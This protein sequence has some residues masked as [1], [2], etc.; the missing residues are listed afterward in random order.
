M[1]VRTILKS[2][3]VVA[4]LNS[5]AAMGVSTVY[6]DFGPSGDTYSDVS[7][8]YNNFS[9]AGTKSLVDTNNASSAISLQYAL[10]GGTYNYASGT[11]RDP[12]PGISSDLT[13]DRIYAGTGGAADVGEFG[14]TLTFSG[15]DPAGTCNITAWPSQTG[16]S[17][18]WKVAAGSGDAAEYIQD[19][20]TRNNAFEWNNITP[21]ASG[22]VVITGRATSN[23]K[24]KSVGLSGVAITAI[25][26][27]V[28]VDLSFENGTN[29]MVNAKSLNQS[30]QYSLQCCTNL[31][32][33]SWESFGQPVV[34]V[35]SNSWSD[36][37]NVPFSFY[38]LNG[39]DQKI[40][41]ALIRSQF[42]EFYSALA[43]ADSVTQANLDSM[44]AGG[45]W[46]DV[47]YESEATASWP[48]TLHLSRLLSMAESYANHDSSFYEDP[49]LLGA[50][51][52]GLQHWL[53]EDYYNS[54]WFN[55]KI[56][57]P[58][59]FE[60]TF[61]LL[62]DDLPSAMY[63]EAR[64]KIFNSTAMDMTGANQVSLATKV[65]MRGLL[66]E[67]ASLMIRASE[68][69]W[70]ELYVTTDEGIQPDWSFH[71]HGPQQQF[72]N[73]GLGMTAMMIE[74][75]LTMRDTLYAPAADRLAILRN[76]M[77]EG[78]SWV[79]WN[80][81]MDISAVGRMIYPG[82]QLGKGSKLKS[83]L[84]DMIKIDSAATALYEQ[85]LAPTN[86][87]VGHKSF[88]R[89]DMAVHRRP[90]WYSSV[91][92]C[93]TRVVGTETANEQ[94][95]L[96]IH[97][98]DGVHYVYQ[99][100]AEYEDAMGLWDWHRLSG[101]TCDQGNHSLKPTG[102]DKDYGES[103]FVGVLNDGTNGMATM[104]YKRNSL[105]A[106]KSWF[107]GEDSVVCLGAGIGGTTLGSVY[108]SVQQSWLNGPVVTASGIL[109]NGTYVLAA[110]SWVQHNGIGYHMLQPS[111]LH[112]DTVTGNWLDI[113]STFD[114]GPVTGSVFSIWI[115][116]GT[117]PVDGTYAYTLYP[118]TDAADMESKI[119]ADN[120]TVLT[121]S[122]SL[123]AI[124]S[125]AGVQ[126][127]FYSAGILTTPDGMLVEV[128]QPCLL[129]LKEDRFIACEP[130]QQLASLTVTVDGISYPV[131]LS[132]GGF[133]GRQVE[134]EF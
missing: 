39:Q 78:E 81:R 32:L 131:S 104:I 55:W 31:V 92:M 103:A 73:Y 20:T 58:L 114:D 42:I 43:P 46:A 99:D 106:R 115:D 133:A 111:T 67:D 57:V 45:T 100:G 76:F 107:F 38:R 80:G 87:I 64:W 17:S 84:L 37:R 22:N 4:A 82:S 60:R 96:G 88:W 9:G 41:M 3:A 130:T 124:E 59:L 34:G 24:W 35:R 6:I 108:T 118:R 65:F 98:A 120:T 23:S 62:D 44:L 134:V 36:L 95:L 63:T 71:Q 5:A 69:L 66:D 10:Y 74:Q 51:L 90:D 109:T 132:A 54:N 110:D 15:L 33:G 29:V 91:K 123:Q 1:T 40:D 116:H 2:I 56:A 112:F 127:A 128:D 25:P 83:Q 122:V 94:N 47:D 126:A 102:Y 68:I 72:G 86:A 11:D 28:T 26:A 50:I 125:N 93:S 61:I 77:L 70:S 16:V 121:N 89:S 21:D 97:L 101:T 113:N 52:D 53:D 27:P 48:T 49:V 85:A 12:I 8:K 14:C 79:L 30:F 13:T 7:E 117:S 75:G 18:T 105:S 19:A 119:Q 129:M